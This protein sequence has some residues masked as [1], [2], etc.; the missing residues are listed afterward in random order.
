MLNLISKQ[1]YENHKGLIIRIDNIIECLNFL[2]GLSVLTGA[3]YCY[4]AFK[5]QMRCCCINTLILVFNI[6]FTFVFL[7]KCLDAYK[8]INNYQSSNLAESS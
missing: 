5:Y 4:Y 1:T 3:T 7:K 6:G 2:Y 8:L